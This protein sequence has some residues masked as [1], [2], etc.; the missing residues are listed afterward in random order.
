MPFYFRIITYIFLIFFISLPILNSLALSLESRHFHIYI[1]PEI[2]TVQLLD[3]LK[4]KYFLSLYSESL[5]K[6][7]LEYLLKNLL[8]AIYLETSDALDIHMYSFQIN[9]DI[10]PNRQYL[11]RL[12][13]PYFRN[14]SSSPSFYVYEQNKIYIS[15]EDMTLGILVHEIAHAIVSHYFVIP[16]PTKVQEILSG[17]AEYLVNKSIGKDSSYNLKDGEN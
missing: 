11:N 3:K 4:V 10:L 16:P 14:F 6:D 5:K 2:N 15:F 1:H 9:I 17:Y 12:L 7:D 8:D 13:A